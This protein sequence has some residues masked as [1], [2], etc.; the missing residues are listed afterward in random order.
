MA[1]AENTIESALEY[2][3]DHRSDASYDVKSGF[4][5]NLKKYVETLISENGVFIERVRLKS[6]GVVT[7]NYTGSGHI[8]VCEKTTGTAVAQSNT[9]NSMRTAN[10]GALNTFTFADCTWLDADKQYSFKILKGDEDAYIADLRL[11]SVHSPAIDGFELIDKDDAY[12]LSNGCFSGGMVIDYLTGI[13]LATQSYLESNYVL[14]SEMSSAAQLEEE[15]RNYYRTNETSSSG[16]ISA[17][18]SAL[19]RECLDA[20]SGAVSAV[21]L[22]GE[23]EIY[24]G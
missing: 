3:T 10:N 1:V 13:Q 14:S 8:V 2:T 22:Y 4:A 18:F 9:I 20:V 12:Q 6:V 16:E 23:D 19:R 5:V 17:A 7:S 24:G 21:Y 11:Y 15:F